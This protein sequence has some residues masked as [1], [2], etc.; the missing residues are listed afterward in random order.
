MRGLVVGWFAL[1]ALFS[2][3]CS[4]KSAPAE[5]TGG[6][7]PAQGGGGAATS[8]A[9]QGGFGGAGCPYG[10]SDDLRAI[11][12]CD[13]D[14]IETCPGALACDAATLDCVDACQAAATAGR[15]I[16]CSYF[17]TFMDQLDADACFAAFVANTW[18]APAHVEVAYD[19][20]T[21]PIESFAYVPQGSG[22][23]ISYQP[24]DPVLGLPPGQVVIL[25]LSGPEGTAAPGQ[26]LCPVASA[27]PTGVMLHDATG[28]GKSFHITSDVPV[29]AYQMNPY[30]GGSAAVTGASLLLPTSAWGTNY[31]AVNGYKGGP[32]ATS[33]NI[34]AAEDD[35]EVTMLPVAN[36]VGGGGLPPGSANGAFTF[37]LS[38]GQHAQLTQQAE[39]T[40]SI[41][42]A[43]KPVGLMAGGRCSFVP[44]GVY[45][46]DHLEQMIPP[47]A[48]L[49]SEYVGV[50]HRPR[51]A[52]PAVWRVIGAVDGTQLVW[53]S[54]V[55]GPFALDRG[56]IAEFATA[57]PFVVK[58]QDA[59]HPFIL[60]SYMTGG[61]TN[62][63]DGIG[64]AD[65]VIGVPPMQWL[66]SYTFFA[67]PSYPETNLVV[68]RAKKNGVF[69][70]VVLDCAGSL[71]GWTKV[72]DYEWT[73][74]DLSTGDFQPVGACAAGP[75]T[76]TSEA[77]FGLTVWGWGTPF[78]STF[79]QY[80]SYGYPAGM[81][82]QT[83]NDVVV[84][85]R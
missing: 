78:T 46:C 14:V 49:G 81:N 30:G 85:P 8:S 68:V 18:S 69:R 56:Q 74:V 4:A 73:R 48:A 44:Q 76:I 43:S 77:R 26:A 17:A 70:E 75:H 38:A 65:A 22:A 6:A 23:N 40:G 51:G 42:E 83:I 58:S 11:I 60:M 57:Q 10:C 12:D 25:F 41:L 34:V 61:S 15:S 35:T 13:E 27:V 59:A 24:Y 7:S 79:T 9:A 21:L 37:T 47:I 31:V 3:G 39:L 53:S 66:R 45:A 28:K 50:M 16:G 84:P 33:L 5:A 20:A 32:Q 55:N 64:D 2:F 72:G 80:V 82:V 19:G 62:D 63:M 36:I 71:G 52:E 67:D 1:G 29:V 54:D